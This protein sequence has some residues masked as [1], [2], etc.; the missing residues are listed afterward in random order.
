M[1]VL[2]TG[3]GGFIGRQLTSA[4]LA[5]GYLNDAMGQPQ[6]IRELILADVTPVARASS[7]GVTIRSEVGDVADPGFLRHLT[8]GVL[9]GIFHLAAVL[10]VE[11]ETTHF[12][13]A[14]TV[15][16]AAL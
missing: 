15:N 5:R 16:V 6:R 7:G 10:T 3:A 11:A 2:I 4:L 1:R 12:E 14:L 9:D 13:R 8:S